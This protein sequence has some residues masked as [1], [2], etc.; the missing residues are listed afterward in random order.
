MHFSK[1]P[2]KFENYEKY[3]INQG[4]TAYIYEY[5]NITQTQADDIESELITNGFKIFHSN[6]YRS[7]EQLF[8]LEITLAK[9]E[10]TF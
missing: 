1:H 5:L 3:N 10:F 8:N 6:L 2:L 9:M 4:Y 7:Q